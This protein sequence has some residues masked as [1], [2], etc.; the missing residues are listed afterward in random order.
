MPMK[1]LSRLF[2]I[3][4][5]I[6]SSL[7]H[8]QS[9]TTVVFESESGD[10]IGGGV[11]QTFAAP[12]WNIQASGSSHQ[13][14]VTLSDGNFPNWTLEFEAPDQ[15]T[16]GRY[17]NATRYP[18]NSSR[19]PGLSVSGNGRGC[20]TLSGWFEVLE[21]LVNASGTPVR[22][23]INFRQFCDGSAGAL[24]GA[25]RFNSTVPA[26]I[27][28][29]RA[30]TGRAQEVI[31]GEVV[32]LDGGQSFDRNTGATPSF[33]WVQTAG[34]PVVLDDPTHPFPAFTAPVVPAGGETAR[35]ALTYSDN[36]G[37]TDTD[38]ASVL[39]HAPGDRVTSVRFSG[40]G[41]DYITGG[42]RYSF[43]PTN[44]D[45]V[46]R[47]LSGNGTRGVEISID[48]DSFWSLQF[49]APQNTPFGI[50]SYEGATRYPFQE[51]T[52]P[53]LSVSGDGRGCNTLTGRFDVVDVAF[54]RLTNAL[55][56]FDVKFE[57]HCEGGASKLT[58]EA[59]FNGVG[60]A[61]PP[62]GPMPIADGGPDFTVRRGQFVTLDG[63]RSTAPSGTIAGH[64]WMQV[65][66]PTV[67]LRNPD[68]A[69]PTFVA[70]LLTR[71]T[72]LRFQLM[73][74][75]GEGRTGIDFVDVTVGTQQN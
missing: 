72:V 70:P 48:G 28:T 15:L 62:A 4:F 2:A 57:Q 30:V 67:R 14:R 17:G 60:V 45:L 23:A 71:R 27:P 68:T 55:T 39:I 37:A 59:K 11:N 12:Q 26:N 3:S 64:H 53:G 33:R 42:R 58:G 25:V 13:L 7:L 38:T 34:T 47:S 50:G 16:P 18:F 65:A 43:N 19:Q 52:S 46:F 41:S 51:P 35:F 44:S 20:N 21:F 69:R 40:D 10:Y 9:A 49:V 24:Y 1:T 22:V 61:V 32:V 66:G 73:V 5:L 63:S 54:D 31:S 29:L 36:T 75:D 74:V 56:R 8:A 6:W